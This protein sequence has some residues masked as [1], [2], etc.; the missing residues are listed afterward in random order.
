MTKEN[1]MG[2]YVSGLGT[3]FLLGATAGFI[4]CGLLIAQFLGI[5]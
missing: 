4:S 3:G 2:V 1:I 5:I